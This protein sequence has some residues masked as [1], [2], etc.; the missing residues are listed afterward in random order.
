MQAALAVGDEVVSAGGIFGTLAQVDD[1]TVVLTVAPGVDV[2]V[3]RPAIV[4]RL[5]PNEGSPKD[6]PMPTP[7]LPN[8]GS[9][10]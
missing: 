6:G 4:R 9:E 8:D 1:E 7:D 3:A 2:T 10:S 5:D